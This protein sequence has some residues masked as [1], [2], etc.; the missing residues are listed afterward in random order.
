ML[1]YKIDVVAALKAAGYKMTTL[2]KD[3]VFGGRLIDQIYAG[4]VLGTIGL[5]RLCELLNCQPGD[6][7]AWKP[8]PETAEKT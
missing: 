1:Y 3:G 2:K 8:D 6:L 4:K 5:D 7:I